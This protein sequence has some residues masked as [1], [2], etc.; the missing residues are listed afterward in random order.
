MYYLWRWR[1]GVCFMMDIHHGTPDSSQLTKCYLYVLYSEHHCTIYITEQ[2][3]T[4]HNSFGPLV[5]PDQGLTMF[6]D[7][8]WTVKSCDFL[9]CS[10]I[11]CHVLTLMVSPKLNRLRW[12]VDTIDRV[13]LTVLTGYSYQCW[14][15]WQ[16]GDSVDSWQSG[17]DVD[18]W[19]C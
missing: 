13:L 2:W 3:I 9:S 1:E 5:L 16:K 10:V 11:T 12:T 15:C 7:L 6:S 19:Q 14:Q 17:V 4:L 8:D 18:W